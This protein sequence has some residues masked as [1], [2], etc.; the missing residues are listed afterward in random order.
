[1][2]SASGLE[3]P[4]GD[5]GADSGDRPIALNISSLGEVAISLSNGVMVVF[6]ASLGTARSIVP[7][8]ILAST[9]PDSVHL[10]LLALLSDAEPLVGEDGAP[11]AMLTLDK[12]KACA[13]GVGV[14]VPFL[15]NMDTLLRAM[16][17]EAGS[18]APVEPSAEIS[19]VILLIC[20]YVYPGKVAV[21]RRRRPGSQDT[22]L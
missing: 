13:V 10:L 3:G 5:V 8:G 17:F 18:W 4:I 14:S 9:R 6:G 1:V 11:Q 21:V 15:L 2:I 22:Q 16:L 19:E 7:S 12:A 20:V